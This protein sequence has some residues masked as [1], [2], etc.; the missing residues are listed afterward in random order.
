VSRSNKTKLPFPPPP[1]WDLLGIEVV[2]MGGGYSKLIMPFSKKLT[3]P[4][5]LVHGGAIFTLADSAVAVS[6]ASLVK[7]EKKFVTIEMKI[8]FMEPVKEGIIEARAVVLRRGR[9]MPAEVDIINNGELVAK[10]ITTYIILDENNR[11]DIPE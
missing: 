9:I 11:L 3:Q 4:Y 6:I 10:A 2:G 7:P 5:G 1:I 8:N